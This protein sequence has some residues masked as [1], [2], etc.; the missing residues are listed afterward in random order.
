MLDIHAH[1][2]DSA[3]DAD[4]DEVVAR[5]FSAGATKIIT[6]GTDVVESRKAVVCAERYE[7]V[8]VSVGVHPHFFNE[9]EENTNF[10][11]QS[12]NKAQNSKHTLQK[13]VA[14]LKELAGHKKVVA[15]GECGLD[16]FVREEEGGEISGRTAPKA[17]RPV[18]LQTAGTPPTGKATAVSRKIKGGVTAVCDRPIISEEQKALQ[19]EGFLAQIELAKELNLPLI[20][21]CRPS[22]GTMPARNDLRSDSGG[23]AYEDMFDILS[24]QNSRFQIPDSKFILHCYMGDTEVTRKFLTLP[25]VYFSFTGNITYPVKKVLAGSKDDLTETVRM[26][27]I[28][29]VL[30]ETDCPY[31]APQKY[32]GGR[33]EP[34][35][36]TEVVGKIAETKG[37]S[38]EIAEQTITA[39]AKRIFGI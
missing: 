12:P 9:I 19:K 18:L 14:G 37:I 17:E 15:I 33:N 23:D 21:H 34:A 6:I 2:H 30:A 3:F 20:I 13:V 4:R 31:L 36:V 28:E 27:P 38:R 22:K 25:N 24:D 10:K 5:A 11:T 1:L 7:A 32:R 29:R 8:Y 26:I 39:S 35:F 16:Y